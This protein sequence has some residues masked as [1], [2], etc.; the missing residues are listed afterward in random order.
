M[1][2]RIG[3]RFIRWWTPLRI[4]GVAVLVSAFLVGI[5]GYLSQHGYIHLREATRQI[6]AYLSANVSTELASIA[7]TI[8]V[9]DALYEHRETERE[10]RRLILQMGSPDNAF[11]REAV[12]ALHSHEWLYDG[13]LKRA[14]LGGANL[15]GAMLNDANLQGAHLVGANLQKAFLWSAKLQ[16]TNL[17]GAKLQGATLNGAKLQRAFLAW[18]RLQGANLKWA[19]LQ[20]ANLHGAK[21]QGANLHDA[22]LQGANL[23]WAEYNNATTWPEGFTPPP[24]AV[25]VDAKPK[26][27]MED[28]RVHQGRDTEA[29]RGE[30]R[31]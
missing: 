10:K 29:N 6:L 18:A 5:L 17:S 13:S 23:K 20:G 28:E 1:I 15:Q 2:A 24:E 19:H 26:S 16:E 30:Q 21:L 3:Q 27:R 12:R 9:V 8:L 4:A 14:N 31:A 11:A 22:K 25:N 7:I